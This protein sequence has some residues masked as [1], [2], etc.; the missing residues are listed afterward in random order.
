MLW[1]VSATEHCRAAAA[2]HVMQVVA[3]VKELEANNW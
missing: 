3:A 1:V 2:N